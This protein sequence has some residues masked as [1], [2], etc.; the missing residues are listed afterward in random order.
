MDLIEDG[1]RGEVELRPAER[2]RGE[3][4][5]ELADSEAAT[6]QRLEQG[7][8]GAGD[9]HRHV[10]PAPRVCG[11]RHRLEERRLVASRR[12][13]DPLPPP[14]GEGGE[15]AAALDCYRRAGVA[16]PVGQVVGAAVAEDLGGQLLSGAGIARQLPLPRVEG[17]TQ[18][19][20]EAEEEHA[21]ARRT[22]H[23]RNADDGRCADCQATPFTARKSR[24]LRRGS[25]T[26]PRNY[27]GSCSQREPKRLK[28]TYVRSANFRCVLCGALVVVALQKGLITQR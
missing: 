25:Q 19:E 23:Q 8:A 26:S 11:R 10:S 18:P 5:R 1:P 22:G 14:I 15:H 13:P 6:D 7:S 17:V 28:A 24:L 16:P 20:G 9:A 4:D 12:R 2:P 3:E 27:P 21:G